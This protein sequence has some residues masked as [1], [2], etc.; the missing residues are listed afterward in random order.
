MWSLPAGRWPPP[1]HALFWK[2]IYMFLHE[3]PCPITNRV[4][5][6]DDMESFF[7]LVAMASRARLETN[8]PGAER[9]APRP[10][11]RR[12]TNGRTK[13]SAA[14]KLDLE[15]RSVSLGRAYEGEV[16]YLTD[17]GPREPPKRTGE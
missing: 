10:T 5:T 4:V 17:L 9:T 3:N 13:G 7:H 12:A 15:D 11:G 16:V 2:K 14:G 1:A 8:A 6:F